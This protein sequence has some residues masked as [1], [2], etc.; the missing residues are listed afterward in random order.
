MLTPILSQETYSVDYRIGARDL[1]EIRVFG[2]DDLTST[3]RVSEDGNIS[4]PLLKT[5]KVEDLTREELEVRLSELFEEKFL[6]NPQVTIFIREYRSKMVSVIGAVVNQGQ[7]ELLG[8]QSLVEIL[9]YA[10]GITPEAG[11][12]IFVTRP[13]IDGTSQVLEIDIDELL[14][15][16]IRRNIILQPKDIIHVPIDR[17]VKVYV[18]GKVN[19][20]GALEVKKSKIPTLLQAIAEAGGFAE[21]ASK[22]SVKIIR[23]DDKGEIT[24]TKVNVD[25]IIDGKQSDIILLEGDTVYVGQSIF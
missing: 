3:V 17:L 10:G 12:M 7:Y 1:L 2:H 25:D 18:F 22:G 11:Q 4:L 8:R 15:G 6:E 23:K 14:T 9:T 24:T 19:N 5:V 16:D 21:R 13:N 20:P